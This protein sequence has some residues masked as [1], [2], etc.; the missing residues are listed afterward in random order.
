MA[1][2]RR[3]GGVGGPK[4]L[5]ACHDLKVDLAPLR[6]WE[7]NCLSR[8]QACAH[9]NPQTLFC[10][11]GFPPD[12]NGS[13]PCLM[14]PLACM[15]ASRCQAVPFDIHQL[16]HGS[17][18]NLRTGGVW[19]ALLTGCLAAPWRHARGARGQ[20]AHAA[21]QSHRPTLQANPERQQLEQQRRQQ[22]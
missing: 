9:L 6:P 19:I 18:A 17:T 10:V 20:R 5:P 7:R 15:I 8:V 22:Q 16:L 4:C 12:Q 1:A 13:R 3:Q 14:P 11:L 2:G 21:L